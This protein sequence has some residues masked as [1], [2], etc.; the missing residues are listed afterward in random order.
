MSIDLMSTLSNSGSHDEELTCKEFVEIVTDYFE[1]RLSTVERARFDE[2]LD[3]C[4]YCRIYLD[5][6]RET[7]NIVGHLSEETA[8]PQ[9]LD[10]LLA[11]F[12]RKV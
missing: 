11:H 7:I 6:M 3:G 5:Q 12:R 8:P 2:H 4:P 10:A 1:H 9:A